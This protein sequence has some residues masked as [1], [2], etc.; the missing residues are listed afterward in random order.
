MLKLFAF[1]GY[2][3]KEGKCNFNN[4]Y[5]RVELKSR[6]FFESILDALIKYESNYDE[7][8]KLLTNIDSIR[9]FVPKLIQ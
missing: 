8:E 9:Y 7:L 6:V 5:L 2:K 3:K 1:Y 4:D